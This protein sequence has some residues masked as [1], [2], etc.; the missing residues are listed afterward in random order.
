MRQGLPGFNIAKVTPFIE[1]TKTNVEKFM[2]YKDFE[3]IISAKRMG[4]FFLH[5]TQSEAKSLGNV[6]FR[7]RASGYQKR[8]TLRPYITISFMIYDAKRMGK[9]PL[10]IHHTLYIFDKWVK[11]FVLKQ[12]IRSTNIK[13]KI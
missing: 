7:L 13:K 3:R 6:H 4:H 2:E 11:F 1:P 8:G 5:V 9:H 12:A 10:I